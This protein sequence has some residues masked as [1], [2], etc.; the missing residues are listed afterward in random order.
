MI[1]G[2]GEG[3]RRAIN[4]LEGTPFRTT[5]LIDEESAGKTLNGIE[6]AKSFEEKIKSVRA[7]FITDPNLNPEDRKEIKERC[8][9]EGI[10][11]HDYTGIFMNLGGRI[12]VTGLME[13]VNGKVTLVI[14][15]KETEYENGTE[16][17]KN[18][19]DRYDIKSISEAKIELR[20]PSSAAYVGYEAW[21]QQYKE[22]TGEDVSFF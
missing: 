8:E 12:P 19:K 17:L 5:V 22:Q 16:A 9:E 15:G 4:F 11:L 6:I 2:A 14:D 10:E 20:K 3:A 1:I 21:A 18:L 7:V 13:L